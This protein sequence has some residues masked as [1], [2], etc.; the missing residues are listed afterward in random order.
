MPTTKQKTK[1]FHDI[2]ISTPLN[3]SPEVARQVC[4]AICS[5]ADEIAPMAAREKQAF[6]VEN[7]TIRL[8]ATLNDGE[9]I[10]SCLQSAGDYR[11]SLITYPEYPGNSEWLY[12]EEI[13]AAMRWLRNSGIA[14]T[15]EQ[16]EALVVAA[17]LP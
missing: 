15:R 2:V 5:I 17:P 7:L 6:P 14:A 8:I 9:F 16:V 11:Y 4:E 10:F 1:K 12:N 3:V 13:E